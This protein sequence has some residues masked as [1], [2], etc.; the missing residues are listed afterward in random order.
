MNVWDMEGVRFKKPQMKLMGLETAKSSTPS[1]VRTFMEKVIF[2]TLNSDEDSTQKMIAEYRKEFKDSS[3]EDISFPRGVNN[4]LTYAHFKNIYKRSGEAGERGKGCPIHVRGSL[5]YNHYIKEYGLD[6]EFELIQEADKIKFVY[7]KEPNPI[8]ENVIA[9]PVYF[10]EELNLN[11]Y[12][13]YDK[14]FEKTFVH[15]MQPI[16]EALNWS[17]K[18]EST[19]ESFFS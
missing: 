4:L 10:P 6:K 1:I 15:P 3:I 18:K 13:D 17:I 5:L 8:H 9:F 16:F 12:V 7:L 14:M 2:S 19:L 11:K